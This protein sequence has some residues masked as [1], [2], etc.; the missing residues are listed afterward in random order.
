VPTAIGAVR[1]KID[2]AN[3]HICDLD[4]ALGA[5]FD[6]RPYSA[7]FKDDLNAGQRIYYISTLQDVPAEIICIVADV[8]QN[9]RSALDHLAYQLVLAAHG[10]PDTN[11]A[12]PVFDDPAKYKAEST[13]KVKGMRQQAVDAIEAVKP[14]KG[15]NDLLWRL[16]RLNNIDKHRLLLAVA[17]H[18]VAHTMTPSERKM[19]EDL[20]ARVGK[21]LPNMMP[22]ISIDAAKFAP[23][24]A[25]DELLRIPIAELEPYTHFHLDVAFNEPEIVEGELVLQTLRNMANMVDSLV[26]SFVQFLLSF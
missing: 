20:Y 9:L 13:R 2:R 6:S 8:L 23:L 4:V 26:T 19:A 16:H 21:P 1:P 12:F 7:E 18:Q 14:Y 10:T 5:F 11:T 15:G 25:G 24:K 22:L 17:S 3:K